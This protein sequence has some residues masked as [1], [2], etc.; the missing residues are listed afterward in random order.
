MAAA[1]PSDASGQRSPAFNLSTDGR[2]VLK[3]GRNVL[4]NTMFVLARMFGIRNKAP[5]VG[6]LDG[7]CDKEALRLKN[8]TSI[9][10]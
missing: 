9:C 4:L 5:I 6:S 3:G 2:S 7:C 10:G 8:Y 1:S